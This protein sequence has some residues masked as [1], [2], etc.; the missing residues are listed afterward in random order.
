MKSARSHGSELR[1]IQRQNRLY[2]GLCGAGINQ[3]AEASQ[4]DQYKGRALPGSSA[5]WLTL[6][7]V[8]ILM[9]LEIQ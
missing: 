1:Q 8:G 6:L 3:L 2:G 9:Q 5:W 7:K 4:E